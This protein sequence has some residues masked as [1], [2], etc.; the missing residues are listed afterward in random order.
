MKIPPPT[1]PRRQTLLAALPTGTA[2]PARALDI[3]LSGDDGDQSLN[4]RAVCRQA[5]SAG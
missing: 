4:I 3:L 2:A 1:P 5:A